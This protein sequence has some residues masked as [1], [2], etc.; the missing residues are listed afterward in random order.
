MR[1]LPLFDV[2]ATHDYFDGGPCPAIELQ[3]D[4]RTRALEARAGLLFRS[5]PGRLDVSYDAD[6]VETLRMFAA[7]TQRPL[8]LVF[9]ARAADPTLASYTDP[10]S[11]GDA[12]QYYSS[13][14][15]REQDGACTWDAPDRITETDLDAIARIARDENDADPALRSLRADARLCELGNVVEP[16]DRILRPLAIIGIFVVLPG[17]DDRFPPAAPTRYRFGFRALRTIWKYHLLGDLAH[18]ESAV[19]A[20]LQSDGEAAEFDRGPKESLPGD[21]VALTFRSRAP[22]PLRVRSDRRLQ[23]R[24][25]GK[26]LIRRLPVASP[27]GI[28]GVEI[29]DGKKRFVSDIYVNG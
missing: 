15:A 21:R 11:L 2:T 23:L 19:I 26:V 28:G 1:Y 5:S 27:D 8:H 25:N 16:R 18:K 29:I 22:I 7:D 24:E 12:I 4:A 14:A 20:D 13:R 9:R 3:P 17:K 6:A 10:D